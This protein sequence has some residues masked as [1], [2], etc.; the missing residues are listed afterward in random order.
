MKKHA[1][2]DWGNL[3]EEDKSANEEALRLENLRLFSAYQ[4]D[5]LPKIWIVTEADRSTTTILFP[6]EY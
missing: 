1:A 4:K 2:G 5:D 6:N 3:S